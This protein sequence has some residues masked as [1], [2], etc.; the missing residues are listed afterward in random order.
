MV[1]FERPTRVGSRSNLNPCSMNGVGCK[2]SIVLNL[3]I[4]LQLGVFPSAY[5]SRGELTE[6]G[7][8]GPILLSLLMRVK[9][10]RFSEVIQSPI[11]DRILSIVFH[12]SL[13]KLKEIKTSTIG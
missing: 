6:S 13:I 10:M 1:A 3:A 11:Q 2:G 5:E 7:I 12:F 4:A 9:R 8:C